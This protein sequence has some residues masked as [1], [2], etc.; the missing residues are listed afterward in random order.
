VLQVSGTQD[1]N[2]SGF[3]SLTGKA[4]ARYDFQKTH[5]SWTLGNCGK[6]SRR[7]NNTSRESSTGSGEG[8]A[9]VNVSILDDGTYQ[10]VAN[11]SNISFPIKGRVDSELEVFR[12]GCAVAMR[13][14]GRDHVPLQRGAGGMIQAAGKVDPRNVTVLSGSIS[15]ELPQEVLSPG[16]TYK[17]VKTTTWELKRN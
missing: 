16:V 4:E 3:A 9:V 14:D 17:R 2:A 1:A 6:V 8:D 11:V 7:M 12:D 5:A 10:V 15:E 13:A